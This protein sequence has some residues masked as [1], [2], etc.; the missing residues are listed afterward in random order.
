MFESRK[1][2]LALTSGLAAAALLG[3]A[4]APVLIAAQAP[5]NSHP[6]LDKRRV[7]GTLTL[8][9]ESHN[10]EGHSS[11]QAAYVLYPQ[12]ECLY[13]GTLTFSSTAPVDIMVYHDVTGLNTEGV[14]VHNVDGK[15]YAVTTLLTNATSGTVDFV[16]AAVLAHTGGGEPYGIVASVDALRKS[17]TLES[18]MQNSACH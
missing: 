1:E 16:G 3:L 10:A 9:S 2:R 8:A 17:D 15:S 12:G 6:S 14:T 5:E 18:G 4:F 11:H 7:T 13:S